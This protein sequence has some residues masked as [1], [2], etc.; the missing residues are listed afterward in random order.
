MILT[1]RFV[2]LAVLLDALCVGAFVAA[3]RESH[4]I[5]AGAAWF[6]GVLWPFAAGWFAAALALRL[7]SQRSGWLARLL[8]NV[9]AGVALGLVLRAAVTHRATPIA[10]IVVAYAFIT[11][12]TLGWRLVVAGVRQLQRRRRPGISQA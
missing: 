7:Y 10:F 5:G 1:R 3:G 9:V 12:L 4:D 11:L 2:P 8:T 6:F